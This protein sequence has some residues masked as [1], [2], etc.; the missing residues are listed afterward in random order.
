MPLSGFTATD[1]GYQKGDAVPNIVTKLDDPSQ[2]AVYLNL[3]DQIW[4]DSEKVENVTA[5]V[6]EHY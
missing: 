3:F 5:A 2:V 6:L 1:L 4:A